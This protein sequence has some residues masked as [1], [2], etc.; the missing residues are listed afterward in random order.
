MPL[1]CIFEGDMKNKFDILKN[2][3][4]KKTREKCEIDDCLFGNLM[5]NVVYPIVVVFITLLLILT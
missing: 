1:I 3:L 4:R 2:V 5:E